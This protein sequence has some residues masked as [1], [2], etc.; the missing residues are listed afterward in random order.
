MPQD[1]QLTF[2][3][4][5]EATVVQLFIEAK[6]HAPSIIYIPSLNALCGALPESCR[7]LVGDSLDSLEPHEPILLLAVMTGSFKSLPRDVRQWFG[8]AGDSRVA[9]KAPGEES[10][11]KF[12]EELLEYV[13]KPP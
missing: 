5:P 9:F 1:A 8:K 2:T 7:A 10:R 3:Q 6:R 4:T 13:K 11:R 12:F